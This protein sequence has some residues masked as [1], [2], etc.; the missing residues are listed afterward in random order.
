M[1]TR[2]S[3]VITVTLTLLSSCLYTA[4]Y[5]FDEDDEVWI[6]VYDI[7]DTLLFNS[8]DGHHTDTVVV[9]RK[10]WFDTYIPFMRNEG[11]SEMHATAGI[12]Y[13][14][15]RENRNVNESRISI[16]KVN[17][18]KLKVVLKFGNRF[19]NEALWINPLLSSKEVNG[20]LYNDIIV[21]DDSNSFLNNSEPASCEYFIW[22]KSKGLL[23]Y[24]YKDGDVYTRRL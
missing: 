19:L 3:A 5:H 21:V 16:H 24:K 13:T 11:F 10:R 18:D 20:E 6:S 9:T 12:F 22:S 1:K 14:I 23:Q 17:N 15:I 4:M 8:T 7:G 2:L